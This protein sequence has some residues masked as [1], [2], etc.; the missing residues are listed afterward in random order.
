M[1]GINDDKVKIFL[2]EF[3]NHLAATKQED[4]LKIV[5]LY[6]KNKNN[7][8]GSFEN[9]FGFAKKRLMLTHT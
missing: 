1:Q 8:K 5:E 3:E 9:T 4:Y 7:F 2:Q 6:E